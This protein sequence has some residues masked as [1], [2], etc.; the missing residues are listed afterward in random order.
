[1]DQKLPFNTDDLSRERSKR[2]LDLSSTH[3]ITS[4]ADWKVSRS[5]KSRYEKKSYGGDVV[6]SEDGVEVVADEFAYDDSLL[7]DFDDE[8]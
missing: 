6:D 8:Y 5:K 2:G 1:M 3:G 4:A 7:L